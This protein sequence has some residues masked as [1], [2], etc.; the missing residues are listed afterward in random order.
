MGIERLG[1]QIE[2]MVDSC[3][4]IKRLL[5]FSLTRK[6][7]SDQESVGEHSLAT[8]SLAH[9]RNMEAICL[10]S[11]RLNSSNSPACF[12]ARKDSKETPPLTRASCFFFIE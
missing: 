10:S 7:Q 12:M 2:R 8:G 9:W 5:R 4:D 11:C 3:F 1:I 6:R